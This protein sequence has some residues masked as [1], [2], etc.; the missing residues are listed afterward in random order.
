[1]IKLAPSILSADFVELGRDI[2][3]LHHSPADYIHIDVMD[4]MFVPN[5][6]FGLPVISSIRQYTDKPFDVHLMIMEPIRYITDFVKAGADIITVHAEAC[7]HLH[8]T[9][10]CIKKQGVKAGV[11][12]NPATPLQA[13][14]YVLD[15]V[16]M[17]LLMTVDPGF[18]GASFI[19]NVLPKIRRLKE[20]LKERKLSAEIEVDGGIKLDNVHEVIKAGANV[21]VAGSAVFDENIVMNIANFYNR[22]KE[23]TNE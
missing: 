3:I 23:V 21:L 10:D 16:D 6:S 4:G 8:R 1:M 2:K 15:D 17:V 7:G 9:I 13:V 20:M 19:P 18:G 14:E 11:V 12:L 22:F 5:I